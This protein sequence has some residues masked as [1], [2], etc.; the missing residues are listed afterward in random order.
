MYV[1]LPLRLFEHRKR[2]SEKDS[3]TE[4]GN[5]IDQLWHNHHWMEYTSYLLPQC[6]TTNNN[7]ISLVTTTDIYFT[8]KSRRLA[9][10]GWVHS[11][12]GGWWFLNKRKWFQ[13]GSVQFNRSVVSSSLRPHGLQHARP[14]CPSPTPRVY[15]NSCPLSRWCYP[16]IS[17]S[18]ISFSSHLQFFPASGSVLEF[19]LQHQSLQWIVRTDFL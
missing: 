3:K 4:E 10:L 5:L 8:Q 14:P 2:E 19:Q 15:S 16:T 18:V 12:S 7:E 9:D 11:F 13:L 17:S 1:A 6:H